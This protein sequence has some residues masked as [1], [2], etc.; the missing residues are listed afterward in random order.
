MSQ[1][2]GRGR[3]HHGPGPERRAFDPRPI[4]RYRG[5]N[6]NIPADVVEVKIFRKM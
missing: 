3:A 1:T 2:S 5:F 4:A 6:Y